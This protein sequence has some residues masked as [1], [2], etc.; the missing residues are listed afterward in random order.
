MF[1]E[2]V[3]IPT[4]AVWVPVDQR[5][6]KV[7]VHLMEPESPDSLASWGFFNAFFERKEYAESYVMEPY[8]KMMLEKDTLLKE[9]FLK[10]LKEDELFR[11]NPSERLDFF[12]SPLSFLR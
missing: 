1:E 11:N 3:V 6:L 5:Q 8:A 4:G 7:I 10:K 9:E 12:L 2:E